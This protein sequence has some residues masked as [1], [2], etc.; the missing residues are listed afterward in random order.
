MA[1]PWIFCS[2]SHWE[3]YTEKSWWVESYITLGLWHL[4]VRAT[5]SL[6]CYFFRFHRR[7]LSRRSRVTCPIYVVLP[8]KLLCDHGLGSCFEA[9]ALLCGNAA[10]RWSLICIN[11]CTAHT[12][13]YMH[14]H[15][16]TYIYTYIHIF[17]GYI[18]TSKSICICICMCIYIYMY[19]HV[20]AYIYICIHRHK[21]YTTYK[22]II[23]VYILT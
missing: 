17:I 6:T 20:H 13:K 14:I 8:K 15:I 16:N 3:Y 19:M 23:I 9:N 21:P 4:F 1:Y 11:E 18:Y 5:K 10:L 7:L 2:S 22:Y 12:Y